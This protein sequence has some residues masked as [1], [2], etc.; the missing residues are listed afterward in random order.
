GVA[1]SQL[2]DVFRV[3]QRSGPD[4]EMS[5]TLFGNQHL[6][7]ARQADPIVIMIVI[8]D[9]G[10][11]PVRIGKVPDLKRFPLGLPRSD[12]QSALVREPGDIVNIAPIGRRSDTS[13]TPVGDED[14]Y[15]LLA[16]APVFVTIR[17]ASGN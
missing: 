4:I 9:S 16:S 11:R 15:Q 8:R 7:I 17:A 2:F 6:R 10:R 13:F 3:G 5:Q 12:E 14:L 1:E